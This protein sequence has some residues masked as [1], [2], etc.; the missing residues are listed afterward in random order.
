[1]RCTSA[2]EGLLGGRI[3][4][5][6]LTHAGDLSLPL[7]PNLRPIQGFT[8]LKVEFLQ[9]SRRWGKDRQRL[10]G[11]HRW[12]CDSSN[13]EAPPP[14]LAGEFKA[15]QSSAFFEELQ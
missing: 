15:E 4:N 10:Q 14:S 13:N 8:K 7:P 9:R 12:R 3:I 2:V 5:Q 6:R 11:E 1:M